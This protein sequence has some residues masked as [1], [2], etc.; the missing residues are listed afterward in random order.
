[1][2]HKIKIVF[3]IIISSSILMACQ[4]NS[5]KQETR[6]DTL[7][8]SIYK[9]ESF[10]DYRRSPNDTDKTYA[11]LYYPAFKQGGDTASI[12]KL[13]TE[14]LTREY[15]GNDLVTG[16]TD[17]AAAF[18]MRYD[19]L[20]KND[21]R[22]NQYWYREINIRVPYQQYPYVVLKMDFSEYT[23][24]AHGIYGTNYVNFD[25]KKNRAVE[26]KD[27][28]SEEEIKEITKLAEEQFR[29]QEGLSSDQDYSGYFFENGKFYLPANFSL[30]KNGILFHYGLYEI[31][32]YVSGVTEVFVECE[33]ETIRL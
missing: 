23:G 15:K 22:Y 28:F 17:A 24:G 32:P 29:K 14:L 18:V 30:Q 11:T 20:V 7:T 27:I 25:R 13:V 5:E 6:T 1:M 2:I 8:Y 9:A 19:S 3:G 4:S 26:L 21:E 33:F 10:S 16:I 12:N 31:K